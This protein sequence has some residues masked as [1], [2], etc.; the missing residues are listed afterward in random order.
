[1]SAPDLTLVNHR[2][3]EFKGSAYLAV[4][5]AAML[6]LAQNDDAA[7]LADVYAP[8]VAST[9]ISFEVTPPD[10]HEMRARLGRVQ[11]LAPWLVC[12]SQGSVVGYAYASQHHERAAYRWSLDAA[13]Y[14]DTEWRR[15]GIARALYTA[16]FQLLKLQGFYAVHAGIT[17]PNPGSVGL[18]EGFG[19]RQVGV[20]RKVGYKFTA[21]HDVGWWQL[22]LRQ[23][24]GQPLPPKSPEQARTDDP[25]AWAEAF[26]RGQALLERGEKTGFK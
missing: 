18:H 12:Q 13:V 9:A 26:E 5:K 4:M 24:Q 1:M 3:D 14:V 21:W 11:R 15:R 25:A 19:F 8:N 6:R 20:Y 23:R 2:L 16:L 10:A 7:E 22:E 17:L